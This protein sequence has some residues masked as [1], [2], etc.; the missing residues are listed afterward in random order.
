MCGKEESERTSSTKE[1]DLDERRGGDE[2]GPLYK[3][4]K[5]RPRTGTD[6][7]NNVPGQPRS[8]RAMDR[9]KEQ[10]S[11]ESKAKQ[12]RGAVETNHDALVG[13]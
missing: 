1:T 7:K 9:S 4:D 6:Q 10:R 3:L 8:E 11:P 5:E 13:V 12:G 2:K